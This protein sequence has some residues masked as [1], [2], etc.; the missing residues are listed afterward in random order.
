MHYA[1]WT[2][3]GIYHLVGPIAFKSIRIDNFLFQP[4]D[5]PIVCGTI[6]MRMSCSHRLT[7]DDDDDDDDGGNNGR[8]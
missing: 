5:Y 1:S 6:I 4:F 7:N 3:C 2:V 8:R